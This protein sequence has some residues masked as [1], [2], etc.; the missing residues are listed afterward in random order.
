MRPILYRAL[1]RPLTPLALAYLARR[2]RRGKEHP[3]R[4]RERLGFA[5]SARPDGPVVWVHAASVGEATAVRDV[6]HRYYEVAAEDCGRAM[7]PAG[8][9]RVL[10]RDNR[11][12]AVGRN[13]VLPDVL[14]LNGDSL[15][16]EVAPKN[17][18]I[19]IGFVQ[20]ESEDV[21][22]GRRTGIIV[23]P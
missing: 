13:V 6:A 15:F 19:L 9:V 17:V 14:S 1:T 10:L 2:R 8:N 20:H 4:F 7:G 18:K 21:S 23:F 22:F 11:R 12:E 16:P 3:I 5:H